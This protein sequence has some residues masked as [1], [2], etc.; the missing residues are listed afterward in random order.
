MLSAEERWDVI[1]AVAKDEG[2]E[3][4]DLDCSSGNSGTMRV[5]INK[6]GN[7]VNLD[8]CINVNRRLEYLRDID[9]AGKIP[10]D[11]TIEVSSPGINRRLRRPEHFSGAI[12]E[13]VKVNSQATGS[14]LGTLLAF[15]GVTLEIKR[16][17]VKAGHDKDK[18]EI[19]KIAFDQVQSAYVDFLF[20]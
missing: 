6:A 2:C 14:V 15:D 11:V 9:T 20:E 4:F 17:S 18:D 5:F 7:K 12:N 10:P 8:D 16:D 3:L 19:V 1:A 13:H